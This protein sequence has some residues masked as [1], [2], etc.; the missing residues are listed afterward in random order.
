MAFKLGEFFGRLLAGGEA[1]APPERSAAVDYKGFA[2][3]PM[4]RRQGG[5]WLT[6]GVISKT[7]AGAVKE[8]HFVRAETHGSRELA[9]DFALIKARQIVDE[10]GERIF[11]AD[12]RHTLQ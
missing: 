1:D 10:R 2:I 12:P 8:H 7:I 9:A 5:Q 11:T 4:F 6:A 3:A